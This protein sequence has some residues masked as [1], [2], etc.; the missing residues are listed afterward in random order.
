MTSPIIDLSNSAHATMQ[1]VSTTAVKLHDKFWQPRREINARRTIFS[2][3]KQCRDTGRLENFVRAAGKSDAPFQGIF[4][5]DSDVYKVLEA[6]GWSLATD[7]DS[8]LEAEVDDIIATV[9]AAQ[10][11]DGYLNTYFMF[12]RADQ[13]WKNLKDMHELYCAG[14]L[15]QAAVAHFRGTGK[16]SLLQIATRF[17]DCI[18]K[19]FGPDGRLAACGHEEAEMGLVE[20]Y[21]VTRDERYLVLAQ[22]MVDARGQTPGMFQ[23]SEY[24]Q[25]HLPFAKQDK[26]IGHAVRH[27]Y[28][29]CGAADVVLENGNSGYRQ[30]LENLWQSFVGSQM[31]V[32]GGAGSRYEGE[33]FGAKYELPNDRAYTETCAAIGSVMWQF[34]MLH[35]TGE[36]RF[37]DVMEHTIINAVL[38]GLALDGEH[39]FYENPLEN[40]GTHRRSAWF[41]CACCPPNVARLLAQLPGYFASEGSG[42]LWLHMYADMDVEVPDGEGSVKL[43]VK[44]DM[45]W[46][47]DVAI[48]VVEAN[49]T[50]T[51]ALRIPVW[52]TGAKI[53][54]QGVTREVDAGAYVDVQAACGDTIDLHLPQTVQLLTSHPYVSSNYHQTAI[55]RGA[56]VYCAEQVDQPLH[57]VRT[58]RLPANAVVQVNSTNSGLEGV[59]TLSVTA[60]VVPKPSAN[61]PLYSD[62]RRSEP[63][64]PAEVVLVPYYAWANR[65]AGPM[66]VWLP[67]V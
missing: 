25:D 20:L 59:T 46:Q 38:P 7:P 34:R 15:F 27:V 33:A 17:A 39:Y 54:H 51:L 35:L 2:Q 57:D 21:R 10:Q 8:A 44:A 36:H 24:H 18:Y 6:A 3:I 58:L 42:K 40:D 26:M 22:R 52:A 11:P 30:G 4:F 53:T 65:E 23:N 9:A 45:P 37:A 41:G 47:P 28:L 13:R 12:E 29:C 49:G 56:V 50:V 14:H 5:N 1:P 62:V 61:E 64:V 63:A 16:T 60:A 67:Q 55:Q 19:E 31:Y 43:A 66:R 48:R 32:T